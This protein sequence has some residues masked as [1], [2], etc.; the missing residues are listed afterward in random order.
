MKYRTVHIASLLLSFALAACG[1]G[2]GTRISPDE[3]ATL[4]GAS[5]AAES[6][7]EQSAR[8]ASIVSRSDSLILSTV[9]GTTTHSDLP[10]FRL[11]ANCARTRCTLREPRSGVTTTITLDDLEFVNNA[12]TDFSLTKHEITMFRTH[13]TDISS[14][15]AWMDHAGFAVQT[16]TASVDVGGLNVDFRSHYGLAGGDLTGSR[17]TGISAT[18]QGLMVGT[19]ASGTGNILQGDAVLE[20]TLDSGTLDAAF[21]DIKDLTRNAAH[22]TDSVRFDDVSV[23]RDGTYRAGATGNRIQGGFYGPE[24]AETAGIFEQSGIIGAFGAKKQ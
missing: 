15:G 4:T 14:Y 1:G 20:Y 10:N 21:T 5:P 19:P 9:H 11:R 24:H 23:A 12:T 2:S 17:P 22:T 6:A 3:V 13:A 16:E 8:A 7:V 18:W